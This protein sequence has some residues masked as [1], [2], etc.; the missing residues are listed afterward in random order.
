MVVTADYTVRLDQVFKGP[1][2]LLLHLVREQEVEIHEIEI[3]TICDGYLTYMKDLENLDIEVAAEFLVMAATLM[4]IKSRSL[5]PKEEVDLEAELDPRDELIQRLIEYRRFKEEAGNLHERFE[6]R[7]QVFRRGFRAESEDEPTL[8]VSELSQWDLLGVFSRLMR[9]TLANRA[10]VIEADERPMRWY[11]GR[12]VNWVRTGSDLTLGSLVESA[13]NEAP[14][15]QMMIGTFCALLEL[16]KLGVVTAWQ[17][18]S[19]DEIHIQIT[20]GHEDDID[21]IVRMSGFDDETPA[22]RGASEEA[23]EDVPSEESAPEG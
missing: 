20:E 10:M 5:L 9:E 14:S 8:D 11:V 18:E 16:M 6:D 2:D 13:A 3:S 22:P 1:M 17:P 12:L 19:M 21:D 15:K 7:N 4:S 23:T